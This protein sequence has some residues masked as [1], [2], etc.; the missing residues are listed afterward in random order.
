MAGAHGDYD[1]L[2][3][4]CQE[5]SDCLIH[6]GTMINRRY[7]KCGH[8]FCLICLEKNLKNKPL[9]RRQD[10]G[11]KTLFPCPICG[12]DTVIP[13]GGLAEL[14]PNITCS[15]V[16]RITKNVPDQ[17]PSKSEVRHPACYICQESH[18]Q[19]LCYECEEYYCDSCHKEN[20]RVTCTDH[21]DVIH[22][23]NAGDYQM[24][25]CPEHDGGL[26]KLYCM[27]CDESM[28]KGCR[29]NDGRQHRGHNIVSM[30]DQEAVIQ[31]R[32]Q[33]RGCA[34]AIR[35]TQDAASTMAQKLDKHEKNLGDKFNYFEQDIGNYVDE[36][37]QEIDDWARKMIEEKQKYQETNEGRVRNSQRVVNDHLD[38]CAGAFNYLEEVMN[39]D[40]SRRSLD[41]YK[42]LQARLETIRQALPTPDV[43]F[44]LLRLRR[45]PLPSSFGDWQKHDCNMPVRY[46]SEIMQSR[47]MS[48]SGMDDLH[49]NA[50][51]LS[52]QHHSQ[53]TN[54]SDSTV[55][56]LDSPQQNR[57]VDTSQM[58]HSPIRE[59][60]NISPQ[61][62]LGNASSS[63]SI[64]GLHMLES[65]R[66]GSQTDHDISTEE[67]PQSVSFPVCTLDA[68]TNAPDMMLAG[69]WDKESTASSLPAPQPQACSNPYLNLETGAE[70]NITATTTPPDQS[71]VSTRPKSAGK[72]RHPQHVSGHPPPAL[73]KRRSPLPLEDDGPLGAVPSTSQIAPIGR[74]LSSFTE[75]RPL[76]GA[77]ATLP[78]GA[79]PMDP[80]RELYFPEK[81]RSSKSEA[82]VFK[83]K[84]SVLGMMKR[85]VKKRIGGSSK[86]VYASSTNL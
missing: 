32:T 56:L 73:H 39:K 34:L 72:Y 64:G 67:S 24:H 36:M 28:C 29:V 65:P 25:W 11:G 51:R 43:F 60:G 22:L 74:T 47:R 59:S 79:K 68:I 84:E 12:K 8:K 33:V 37:K 41:F 54:E 26:L 2:Y 45:N 70:I 21:R 76:A 81:L 62:N 42:N 46:D 53:Q 50:V 1:Q 31:K 52:D 13:E 55:F 17:S 44:T 3:S 30:M 20:H 10:S 69:E 16:R 63:S 57:D 6:F 80:R 40:P 27:N 75:D 9:I 83:K 78:Q 19:Y 61:N 4:C 38:S 77:G 35:E 86:S 5:Q 23:D 7:L 66:S 58:L 49:R 71:S 14:P 85:K 15:T 82:Y 18:P 48:S